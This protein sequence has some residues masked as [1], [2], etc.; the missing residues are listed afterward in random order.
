MFSLNSFK[1]F[2]EYVFLYFLNPFCKEGFSTDVEDL[3]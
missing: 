1:F 3:I 2:K